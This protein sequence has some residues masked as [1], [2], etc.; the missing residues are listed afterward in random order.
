MCICVNVFVDVLCN[1][2]LCQKC[3]FLSSHPNHTPL[4]CTSP[5]HPLFTHIHINHY[6]S[7][8]YPHQPSHASSHHPSP[9]THLITNPSHHPSPITHPLTSTSPITTSSHIQ[10]HISHSPS[11]P[12]RK[13][14]YWVSRSS[15]LIIKGGA[16]Y[17]SEQV[18]ND[19]ACVVKCVY[20][21]GDEM[22]W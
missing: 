17:S 1:V 20:G 4:T 14:M 6:P 19:V 5:I 7:P 15:G 2:P 21:L 22:G 12:G 3:E 18:G 11:L 13:D 8:T 16:N 10:T 9:I